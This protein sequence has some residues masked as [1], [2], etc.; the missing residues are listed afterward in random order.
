MKFILLLLF[1]VSFNALA[2]LSDFPIENFSKCHFSLEIVNNFNNDPNALTDFNN[3]FGGENSFIITKNEAGIRS[4]DIHNKSGGF[5]LQAMFM[6]NYFT[7]HW[8]FV[9]A[10]LVGPVKGI[11]QNCK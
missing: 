5:D 1:L 3:A 11:A 7:N 9:G 4:G 10:S 6:W 2:S 8:E